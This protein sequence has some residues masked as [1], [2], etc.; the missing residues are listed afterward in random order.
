MQVSGY[1]CIDGYT[2]KQHSS[3]SS[4]CCT[5]KLKVAHFLPPTITNFSTPFC[6]S[7]IIHSCPFLT[8]S[9]HFLFGLP[10]PF[11]P[12]TFPSRTNCKSPP[13]LHLCVCPAYLNFPFANSNGKDKN[14]KESN[15]YHALIRSSK[16][17]QSFKASVAILKLFF[18]NGAVS[19]F[20]LLALVEISWH[21]SMQKTK[22]HD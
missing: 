15:Q 3:S 5:F 20:F 4:S 16:S 21:F 13:P 17:R 18:S 12:S 10:H 2:N 22:E 9:P 1:W 8:S 6:T 14:E 7:H 19:I 11:L